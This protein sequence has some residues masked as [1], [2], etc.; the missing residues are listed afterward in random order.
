MGVCVET[1][2]SQER[3]QSCGLSIHPRFWTITRHYKT[4]LLGGF[5]LIKHLRSFRL[6]LCILWSY[7]LFNPDRFQVAGGGV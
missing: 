2:R 5:S 6:C 4:Q 1:G 3:E 7:W